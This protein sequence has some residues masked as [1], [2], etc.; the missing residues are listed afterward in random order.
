MREARRRKLFSL[1]CLGINISNTS[2]H[3][4]RLI[5]FLLI[6]IVKEA[7]SMEVEQPE[8]LFFDTFSHD[9]YEVGLRGR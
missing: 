2:A 9:S 6:G 1:F 8:L 7:G 3:I 4:S 5:A